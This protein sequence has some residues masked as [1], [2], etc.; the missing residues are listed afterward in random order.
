MRG[1]LE[2]AVIKYNIRS[3]QG[4]LSGSL[5]LKNDVAIEVVF[6]ADAN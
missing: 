5:G 2:A 1:K 4:I 3:H 6:A